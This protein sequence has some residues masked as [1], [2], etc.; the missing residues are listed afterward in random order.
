MSDSSL[1]RQKVSVESAD[2][3]D[4]ISNTLVPVKV[5]KE[6]VKESNV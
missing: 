4:L 1:V 2:F 5:K 3:S 6:K